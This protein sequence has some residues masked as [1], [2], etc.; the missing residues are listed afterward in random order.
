MARRNAA[1]IRSPRSRF[2]YG[3]PATVTS[4]RSNRPIAA[5]ARSTATC[6]WCGGLKVPPKRP[7]RR[8]A[9][10]QGYAALSRRFTNPYAWEMQEPHETWEPATW[11]ARPISQ[12]PAWPDAEHLTR[13]EAELARRPPLVF[14]GEARRL[15]E[16][17]GEVAG[18]RAFLL[19]AGDC[20]ESFHEG[21]ADAIRDKLKVILQMAV[22]LT[23][24]VGV[25]VIKVGRI[26]GQFAKPR[27][28]PTEERDGVSLE[29]FRGHIVNGEE[30]TPESRRPTPSACWPPT[31]RASPRSTCCAPSPRA[32]SRR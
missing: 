9:I 8:G 26:A 29:A 16:H 17:L 12:S 25:P 15:T 21:S 7:T 4:S 27:T 3:S 30:F 11:R 31:T 19:Q 28:T 20:A 32:G 10:G 1:G 14:A 23:Y 24:A 6:P 18:G 2:W 5:A 22:A 13:V